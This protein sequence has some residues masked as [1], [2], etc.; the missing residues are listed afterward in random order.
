[1]SAPLVLAGTSPREDRVR[2]EH[3]G[4]D[5]LALRSGSKPSSRHRL[6]TVGLIAAVGDYHHQVGAFFRASPT[7]LRAVSV[8]V[9][10]PANFAALR[11][12]HPRL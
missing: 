5:A 6:G 11:L 4:V 9:T 2:D 1:M 10:S 8:N 7:Y 12:A 3:D